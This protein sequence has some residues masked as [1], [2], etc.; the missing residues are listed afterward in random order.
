VRPSG[1]EPLIRCYIEAH[2][3]EVLNGLKEAMQKLVG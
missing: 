3:E 1:T 2:D